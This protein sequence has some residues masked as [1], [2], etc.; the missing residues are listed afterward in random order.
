[1]ASRLSRI[2]ISLLTLAL[3]A[4]GLKAQQT[5]APAAAP[6]TQANR[7]VTP[8][9]KDRPKHESFL[10]SKEVF[11]KTGGTK[12]VLIGDS[13]TDAL[14]NG[15]P[16]DIFDAYFGQYRPYNI[17]I[18]GDQ[19]QHVLWRIDHGELDGISPKV[20]VIMIGTNNLGRQTNEE[21]IDGI[22]AIVKA[23]EDKVPNI[24]ILLLGI[25]PRA[26]KPEDPLRGRI[27]EVNAAIA[28]LD[29]GGKHVKYLDI[30]DKFLEPDGT[31]TKTTMPDFLHP[32]PKGDESWAKAIKPAVDELEK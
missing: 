28:K 19:T 12:L 7:G 11:I 4:S 8:A 30:G 22:K 32:T 29:D 10:A 3:G 6:A 21:T 17:G 2:G 9:E 18:G 5:P 24:K 16:R 23:V 20:A 15:L 13:I 31:I 27:K 1:M 14:H 25:F 26:E